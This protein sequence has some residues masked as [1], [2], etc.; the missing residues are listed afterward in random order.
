MQQAAVAL[1]AES[2][3]DLEAASAPK[4]QPVRKISRFLVSPAILTVA[5]ERVAQNVARVDDP[6]TTS[7]PDNA[8]NEPY[9]LEQQLDQ[10]QQTDQMYNAVN[11][12]QRQMTAQ[13]YIQPDLSRY[14]EDAR[15]HKEFR[16]K[17]LSHCGNSA[18][19]QLLSSLVTFSTAITYRFVSGRI[20]ELISAVNSDGRGLINTDEMLAQSNIIDPKEFLQQQL[21]KTIGPD[22]INSLEQLKIELEN[23]THAHMINTIFVD[24]E[25]Q[26]DLNLAGGQAMSE[27]MWLTRESVFLTRNPEATFCFSLS[28]S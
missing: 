26:F 9:D 11:L 22:H 5:N 24:N 25:A 10:V 27:G 18:A 6:V 15:R 7:E 4:V 2:L 12:E 28:I 3:K 16:C 21:K 13:N 14:V 19:H 1:V 17:S 23:I 20:A 8:P